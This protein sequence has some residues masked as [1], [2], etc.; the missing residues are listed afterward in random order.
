M[1]FKIQKENRKIQVSL[2]WFV[3]FEEAA[4]ATSFSKYTPAINVRVITKG[5]RKVKRGS[6]CKC[7]IRY[8]VIELMYMLDSY[9]FYFAFY[10]LNG[11]VRQLVVINVN[12]VLILGSEQYCPYVGLCRQLI[13]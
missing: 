10:G 8:M 9:V 6:F 7:G 13:S 4:Q 3:R 11:T 5:K 2:I 12:K 1:T